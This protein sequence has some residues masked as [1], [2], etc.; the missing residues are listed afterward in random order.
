MANNTYDLKDCSRFLNFPLPV[1][2]VVRRSSNRY[3]HY[4]EWIGRK[5]D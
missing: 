1:S 4:V 3:R 2:L 5:T